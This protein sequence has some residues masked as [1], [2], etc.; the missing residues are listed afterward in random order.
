MAARCQ[1]AEVV[2][3][4]ASRDV[5]RLPQRAGTC[6]VLAG[7]ECTHAAVQGVVTAPHGVLEAVT[8]CRAHP[9][10][11]A[12]ASR[13]LPPH[14]QG[15]TEPERRTRRT[16]RITVGDEG[17][18]GALTSRVSGV[19]LTGEERG[20]TPGLQVGGGEIGTSAVGTARRRP[21]P[22]AEL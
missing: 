2:V 22:L 1:E 21:G 11:P 4:V 16:F 19:V 13:G 6:L 9:G 17:V 15:Q 18:V 5:D 8:S 7:E 3:A 12:G 14:H 20:Q 10:E